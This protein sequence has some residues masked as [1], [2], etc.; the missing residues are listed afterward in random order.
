MKI[1][2]FREAYK[3]V[4]RYDEIGDFY[5]MVEADCL[6]VQMELSF[7][8]RTNEYTANKKAVKFKIPYE[9]AERILSCEKK[10]LEGELEKLGVE[11]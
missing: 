4:H 9:Q 3:L 8:I 2:D 5:Y 6:A 11:V 10:R 1:D 7:S